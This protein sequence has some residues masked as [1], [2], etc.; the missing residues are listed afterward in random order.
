MSTPHP[1]L[2]QGLTI[3]HAQLQASR[4]S[5]AKPFAGTVHP[6]LTI[7]RETCAGATT[8]GQH[9]LPVLNEQLSEEGRSW[10]FLDKDLLTQALSLNHLPEH[11][12][13]YLPED[14]LPEIKGLIGEM[15]GLHPPLWELEHRVAEAILKF[16]KLGCVILAGRAAHLVTQDLPGGFHLRLV[17]PLESR[18]RRAEAMNQT[19]RA[20]AEQFIRE[21][22]SARQRH[23]QTRFERD[24]NDPHLY[25]LVINTDRIQPA[26]AAQL[27]L[28]AMQDRLAA[29]T[30]SV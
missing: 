5:S 24:I 4:P 12:A 7:S 11:L 30:T 25:D 16:A 28:H 2:H 14:R 18:I 20:E 21:N 22:D 19:S 1:Y 27:V 29:T 13:D 3:L 26:T 17:A 15:V 23:V 10:M 8:L 6:F 9:L